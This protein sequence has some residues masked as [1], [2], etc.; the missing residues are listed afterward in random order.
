MKSTCLPVLLVLLACGPN[1]QMFPG[2]V[3][4][5]P[6][7]RPDGPMATT[8]SHSIFPGTF[9]GVFL[10]RVVQVLVEEAA[11]EGEL[12]ATYARVYLEQELVRG[13]AVTDAANGAM[14]WREG[15]MRTA[16]V[17]LGPEGFVCGSTR[18]VEPEQMVLVFPDGNT[19]E[20][21]T[22]FGDVA[23]YAGIFGRLLCVD[24]DVIQLDIDLGTH[25]LA[26]RGVLH[27][28]DLRAIL[29]ASKPL[30]QWH[31]AVVEACAGLACPDTQMCL[32]GIR[33]TSDL[34]VRPVTRGYL[35]QFSDFFFPDGTLYSEVPAPDGGTGN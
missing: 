26:E 3:S 5:P 17:S 18:T 21:R 35:S 28:E 6:V 14:P 32:F 2:G 9:H 1:E 11:A 13:G 19:G 10:A 29:A 23:R 33:C 30:D 7:D 12:G 4:Q 25:Y 27:M 34:T 31:A 24:D 22:S 8:L 20:W 15:E 16:L